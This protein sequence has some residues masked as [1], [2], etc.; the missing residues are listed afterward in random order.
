MRLWI[1]DNS[2]ETAK[3]RDS[4]N[5]KAF[6]GTAVSK[7]KPVVRTAGRLEDVQAAAREHTS[8][9]IEHLAYWYWMRSENPRV[10]WRPP[11]R[12]WTALGAGPRR[13]FPVIL[14]RLDYQYYW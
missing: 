6:H 9:A 10:R 13:R 1:S 4:T 12:F 5:R 3:W 2:D 14:M 7:G 8:E 11:V